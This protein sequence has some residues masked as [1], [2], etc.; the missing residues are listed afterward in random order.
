L[1][2]TKL[3]CV[4][5]YRDG[6]WETQP[7]DFGGYVFELWNGCHDD[8]VVMYGYEDNDNQRVTLKVSG[9]YGGIVA[10]LDEQ[11]KEATRFSAA[12]KWGYCHAVM[13]GNPRSP[14]K[15]HV[16]VLE[17][18]EDGYEEVYKHLSPHPYLVY[19]HL[20]FTTHMVFVDSFPDLTRLLGEVLPMIGN[21]ALTEPDIYDLH[22]WAATYGRI[23][24]RS[25]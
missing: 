20:G 22:K 24:L 7:P 23:P 12:S 10:P 11:I 3:L 19:V 18:A 4:Y 17:I 1:T 9:K 6:E 16:V 15:P 2:A 5:H 8:T 21:P 14:L 13:Y 25:R